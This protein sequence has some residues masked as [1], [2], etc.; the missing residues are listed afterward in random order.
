MAN[1]GVSAGTH[2]RM[3]LLTNPA[4][5]TVLCTRFWV[6][7]SVCRGCWDSHFSVLVLSH[8]QLYVLELQVC[9]TSPG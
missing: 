3:E 5:I 7:L 2:S 6:F 1:G 8:L 4:R 9:A